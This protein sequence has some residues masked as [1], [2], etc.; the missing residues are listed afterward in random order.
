MSDKNFN[1]ILVHTKD[2]PVSALI[3]HRY[4]NV[5]G[6][7]Y[8]GYILSA[9]PAEI[10]EYGTAI[11]YNIGESHEIIEVYETIPEVIQLIKRLT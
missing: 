7:V 9:P 8:F 2:H 4:L 1:F 11:V 6:I 5:D 3:G 10:Q